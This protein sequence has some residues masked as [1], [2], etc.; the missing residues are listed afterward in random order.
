MDLYKE[1]KKM[2]VMTLSVEDEEV[3]PEVHLQDDLGADSLA[4]VNLAEAIGE[5]YEI[6]IDG[7]DIMDAENLSGI[8]TFV[9]AK[10]SSK[11]RPENPG[12]ARN[13]I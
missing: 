3:Q 7:D 8:V 13:G 6:E 2:I 11:P 4:I 10:I 9:E 12:G 5:R 1:I